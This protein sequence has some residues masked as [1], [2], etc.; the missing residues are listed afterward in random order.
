MQG[1][2]LSGISSASESLSGMEALF[3]EG[4]ENDTKHGALASL[5]T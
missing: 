4:A 5:D 2:I 3:P 1:R